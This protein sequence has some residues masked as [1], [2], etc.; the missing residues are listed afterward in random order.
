[1]VVKFSKYFWG[2]DELIFKNSPGRVGYQCFFTSRVLEIF[3]TNFFC[4]LW[5]FSNFLKS[6]VLE[7]FK[8]NVFLVFCKIFQNLLDS[9][10]VW[11]GV[12]QR[13]GGRGTVFTIFR[14]YR[15]LGTNGRSRLTKIHIYS[16]LTHYFP[17]IAV[18]REGGGG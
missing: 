9:F 15:P 14:R 2:T 8:K 1:M 6:M 3:E 13:S 12:V 10:L 7:I 17:Q 5:K 16:T 4:F 11:G 18:F